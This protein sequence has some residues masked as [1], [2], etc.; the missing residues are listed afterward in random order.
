[1]PTTPATNGAAMKFA[2]EV[3]GRPL[4]RTAEALDA[5]AGHLSNIEAGRR[6]PSWALLNRWI[7]Y[8]P[9][10]DKNLLRQVVLPTDDHDVEDVT[11][12]AV[13]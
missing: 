11:S 1:M 8:M 9:Y 5:T 13:A 4:G 6:R 10:E 2:R 7:E 3:L 12:A